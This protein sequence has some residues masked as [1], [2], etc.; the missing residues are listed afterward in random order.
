VPHTL[1]YHY[2][3]KKSDLGDKVL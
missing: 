1:K 2:E 3:E